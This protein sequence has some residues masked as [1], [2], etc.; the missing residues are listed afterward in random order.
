M[1]PLKTLSN[2]VL[3]PKWW[4][5]TCIQYRTDNLIKLS[6]LFVFKDNKN[7]LPIWFWVSTG[8]LD[9]VAI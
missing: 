9:W 1:M 3:N 8:S 2:M 5:K 6:T 4:P 7:K